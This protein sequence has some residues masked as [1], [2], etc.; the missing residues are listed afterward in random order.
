MSIE[1]PVSYFADRTNTTTN[2]TSQT[3]PSTKT[4][5][6]SN[7]DSHLIWKT[8][9]NAVEYGL[10][11]NFPSFPVYPAFPPSLATACRYTDP[12]WSNSPHNSG[13]THLA[14]QRD[15]SGTGLYALIST[16]ISTLI[17]S[18][19]TSLQSLLVDKN[20][21]WEKSVRLI[22]NIAEHIAPQPIRTSPTSSLS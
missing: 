3:K 10:S 8:V 18:I 1:T 11:L 22:H 16:L 21:L 20:W 7:I 12:T 4:G 13:K 19:L 5:C 17:G 6:W 14:D 15:T 9:W 2:P